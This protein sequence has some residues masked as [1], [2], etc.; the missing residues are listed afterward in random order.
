MK[1]DTK[2]TT[3]HVKEDLYKKF[4]IKAID[5]DINLQKLVNRSMDLYISN[6]TFKKN[7]DEHKITNADQKKF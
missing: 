7:V 2:L 3:V 1:K 4:K 6:D 5:G